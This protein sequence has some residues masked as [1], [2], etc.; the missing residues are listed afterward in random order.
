MTQGSSA[1]VRQSSCSAVSHHVINSFSSIVSN[2]EFIRTQGGSGPDVSEL[3]M[4]G[5]GDHR[6]ST[7]R[8]QGR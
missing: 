2:A 6:D 8:I 1:T 7:R 5:Y 4:T 3:E